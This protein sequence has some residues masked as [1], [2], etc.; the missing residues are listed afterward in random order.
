[1]KLLLNHDTDFWNV[2]LIKSNFP[3]SMDAEILQLPLPSR[4]CEDK[5]VWKGTKDGKYSV[6]SGYH[7]TVTLFE[8]KVLIVPIFQIFGVTFGI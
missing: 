4:E 7:L 1:M 8:L 2:N 6:K 5:F 3:S